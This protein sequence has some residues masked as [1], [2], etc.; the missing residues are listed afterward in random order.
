M[1]KCLQIEA[2]YPNGLLTLFIA[3]GEFVSLQLQMSRSVASNENKQS[4]MQADAREKT[5]TRRTIF[6]QLLANTVCFLYISRSQLLS[7]SSDPKI[8]ISSL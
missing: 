8:F 1:N 6:L 4:I 7:K 5:N 3:N 2:N